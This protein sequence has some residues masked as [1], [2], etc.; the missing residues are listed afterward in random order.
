MNSERTILAFEKVALAYGRKVVLQDV[1]FSIQAGEF[2]FFLGP[3]GEGKT[4]L[5]KAILGEIQPVAGKLWFGPE[6]RARENL[7]FIPQRCDLNPTLPTTVREFVSLG[8]TG[9]R[10]TGNE[11]SRRLSHAL[12]RVGLGGMGNKDY[13]TLSGGQMQ[14]ALVARS[15]VRRPCL[16]ILDEPT[17]GIDLSTEDRFLQFLSSLNKDEDLTVIFVAHDLNM[18][19]RYGTHAALFSRG[20]VLAG[21]GCAVLTAEKLESAYGVPISVGGDSSGFAGIQVR[22]TSGL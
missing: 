1:D 21:P 12:E 11:R 4:T 14:R 20:G 7:S 3:N 19:A 10:L 8:F 13:W 9:L 18:A 22:G 2:W 15:L 16:L 17:K 6:T 5:L